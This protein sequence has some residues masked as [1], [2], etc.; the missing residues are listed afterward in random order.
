[1][2]IEQ[3]ATKKQ[4]KI[5]NKEFVIVGVNKF[6]LN[7][8][9]SISYLEIDNEEVKNNQINNLKKIK[10]SRDESEVQKILNELRIAA[11]EKIKIY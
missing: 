1:M 4:A 6:Q 2:R 3:A 5:D 8:D 9:E 10:N 7:E 11:K